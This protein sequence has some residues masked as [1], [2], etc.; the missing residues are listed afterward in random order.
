MS[1]NT[2]LRVDNV[3]KSYDKS[4][5]SKNVSFSLQKGEIGCLLG[6][7]GC[8]KT[9]LL[10]II[11]GFE[12]IESGE[13]FIHDELVSSA[14]INVVPERRSI[15]MVFQDYA[16]FPHMTVFENVS[17]GLRNLGKKEKIKNVEEI[18]SLVDLA[19]VGK[20]YPHE[21]SGG[22]QQRVALARALVP[23]PDLLLLDEPFS[24]LDAVLRDRLSV[25]VRDILKESGTTALLVTHNQHEAFS[26]ADKI[27]VLFN[28]KMEQWDGAYDIY[29]NPKCIK[30]ARFVGEGSLISGTVAQNGTISCALGTLT[31]SFSTD[32]L[33][34]QVDILIRP[35]DVVHIENGENFAR[36]LHKSFR[37]PNILY[38]LELSSGEQCQALV[39]SHHNHSIDELIGIKAEVN[40]LIVFP[41]EAR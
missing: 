32:Q 4:S 36:I 6:P 22:Q 12:E 7:S 15:G 11:A 29:H 24:N 26:V 39:S 31:G 2:V 3:C 20:K 28:G 37:G 40:H 5:V 34:K 41:V 18:L 8:G 33:G 27:G 23:N 17:F 1:G 9:T 30:V 16:L 25:E 38:R 19:K 13:V 10:R 35:E 21:I 14:D